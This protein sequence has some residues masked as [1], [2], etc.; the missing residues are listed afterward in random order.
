MET[1]SNSLPEHKPCDILKLVQN[2]IIE[3]PHK[4]ALQNVYGPP[5]STF[6]RIIFSG[7]V[8]LIVSSC[9]DCHTP[10]PVGYL[11]L[12][13]QHFISIPQPREKVSALNRMRTPALDLVDHGQ[14][15]QGVMYEIRDG[16]TSE[17]NG[18]CMITLNVKA[19]YLHMIRR[20]LIESTCL[21]T[22]LN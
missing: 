15:L 8:G 9:W 2:Q 10:G 6:T 20:R 11:P 21:L 13:Q 7:K 12:I 22:Y 17:N 19:K 3:L 14:Y 5:F 1:V 4:P 16:C 18:T